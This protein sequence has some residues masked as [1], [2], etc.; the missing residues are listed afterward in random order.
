MSLKTSEYLNTIE[1]M[2]RTFKIAAS[3]SDWLGLP[4]TIFKVGGK[5]EPAVLVAAGASG[6]EVAGVYA[7]LELL[8]QVD[9]ERTTYILPSRDP[10]GL[11]DV[12]FILSR[13]FGFQVEARSLDDIKKALTDGGVETLIDDDELFLTLSKGVG[14]AIGSW[15][16]AYEVLNRLKSK[17]RK[18]ELIDVL[19]GCRILV[20]SQ[21]PQVEGVGSFNRFMTVVVQNG[22]ILT[23]DDVERVDIPEVAF[24]RDFMER[25]E[26]GLVIDLHETKC[27]AF[28]AITS[29]PPSSAESTILYLVL[30]QVARRGMRIADPELIE[31]QGLNSA[32]E[33]IGYKRGACGLVDLAASRSY[34][35]AFA[36]PFNASLEERT[37]GLMVATLS[38]LNAFIVASL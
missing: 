18:D 15:M 20:A 19:E 37:S 6:V 10:T 33:G 17:L 35:F 2:K 22:E 30:D 5:E 13:M 3:T 1:A 23:Y 36:A 9:I 7:T 26:L 11:H 12:S 31:K 4:I 28:H 25:Q 38:A 27:P 34:A 14:I 16:N 29:Y 32:G 21:L 8:V 24:L